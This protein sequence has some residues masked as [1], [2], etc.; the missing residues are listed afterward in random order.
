MPHKGHVVSEETRKKIG[1]ANS[2]SL[3]G[4]V[5]WNK[6]IPCTEENK[7]KIGLSN[8]GHTAWNKESHPQSAIKL[9]ETR[10][11]LFKEGKLK[12]TFLNKHLSETT[13][14][15]IR[16]AKSKQVVSEETR[17]KLSELK[18]GNKNALG[19]HPSNDSIIKMRKSRLHRVYPTKDTLP[20]RLVQDALTSKG[21]VFEKHRALLNICQCDVFIEPKTIVFVDG[22][23]WHGCEQC[24]DKN[25]MSE[26]IKSRKVADILITQKLQSQ[27][28]RVLRFWEHEI[29]KDVESVIY[30]IQNQISNVIV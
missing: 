25:K 2:I 6:G 19:H 10:K 24:F 29:K 26:W 22:C 16:L 5:P 3:I 11:R 23:Y 21:I 4:N 17:K 27:G 9:S 1:L 18:K 14:Q 28:Y 13:K 15:K 7:K 30:K 12:P 8:R 20:E